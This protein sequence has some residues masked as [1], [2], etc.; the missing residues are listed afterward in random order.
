MFE[1]IRPLNV[2]KMTRIRFLTETPEC[3]DENGPCQITVMADRYNSTPVL[4]PDY[5]RAVEALKQFPAKFQIC[6]VF[7]DDK[8]VPRWEAISESFDS[9]KEAL[10]VLTRGFILRESPMFDRVFPFFQKSK[11]VELVA[12]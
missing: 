5:P 4:S 8:G 6:L 7:R 11:T 1:V 12:E 9:K 10:S 2:I 3:H